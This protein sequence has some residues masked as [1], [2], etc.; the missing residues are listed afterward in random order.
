MD[1]RE[2]APEPNGEPAVPTSVPTVLTS[3]PAARIDEIIALVRAATG[4]DGVAPLS[5][6]ALLGLRHGSG[7][8]RTRCVLLTDPGTGRVTGYGHLD[9]PIDPPAEPRTGDGTSDTTGDGHLGD[10]AG[11][12]VVHP[13]DRGRGRGGAL[14]RAMRSATGGA[15]LRVWAHGDLPPA[16]AL[17]ASAGFE[18]VR[19]LWQMRRPL[20]GSGSGSLPGLPAVPAGVRIRTFEPGRD[21][22]AWTRV[23]RLAFADH[24]EQGTWTVDDLLVREREPWFDPAGFFV[25]ERDGEVIGFHWT[26]VHPGEHNGGHGDGSGGPAVGEVYVVGVSPAA[27]GMGLGRVLTLTGLHHLRDRG[28]AEVMLYVDE[29]KP[30]RRLYE[31]LGFTRSN[32]DVMYRGAAYTGAGDRPGS[33]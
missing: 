28:L 3:V 27:Q 4:H 24:P 1:D 23:N 2:S 13:E 17:A 12:L 15:A 8:A 33:A 31:S 9:L 14:L 22:V 30:A 7:G 25:A 16:A 29:D 6:H 10:A 18:R 5:E 21:E 32:V 11:E 19:A 20:A 26:K